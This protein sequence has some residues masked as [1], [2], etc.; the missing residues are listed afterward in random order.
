MCYVFVKGY[1]GFVSKMG[2]SQVEAV[3]FYPKEVKINAT[4]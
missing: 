3:P 4:G 1:A 2:L